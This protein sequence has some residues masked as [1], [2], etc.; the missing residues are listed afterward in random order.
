[1][2]NNELLKCS[3]CGEYKPQNKFTLLRKNGK[4]YRRK[5][6]HECKTKM[7]RVYREN[8]REHTNEIARNSHKRARTRRP[9]S[10]LVYYAKR[11][12]IKRG[13]PFNLTENDIEIP[14]VCPVLGIKLRNPST[15]GWDIFSQDN[16]PS[17]DRIVP[18]L[19]YIKGNVKVISKKA[20]TI[21]SFGTKEE[22]LKIVEYIERCELENQNKKESVK[23]E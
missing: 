17:L 3:M 1:M 13:L 14:E 9:K 18:E 12:A 23:A 5:Q 16:C 7:M 20:N 8:N 21:K 6:C 22:H 11:R 2:K 10:F 15:D 19:G 4:F